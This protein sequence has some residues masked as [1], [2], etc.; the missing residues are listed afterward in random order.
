MIDLDDMAGDETI[1]HL[2]IRNH[3]LIAAQHARLDFGGHINYTFAM[4]AHVSL[5]VTQTSLVITNTDPTDIEP[6]SVC[7]LGD[8]PPDGGELTVPVRIHHTGNAPGGSCNIQAGLVWE[9]ECGGRQN[10]YDVPI[11]IINADRVCSEA[12][13]AFPPVV[14]LGDGPGWVCLWDCRCSPGPPS[15]RSQTFAIPRTL[16]L[17]L[18]LTRVRGQAPQ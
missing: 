16:A 18:Q 17:L 13:S 2:R 5:V 7:D 12:A 14:G 15:A 3:G 6:T 4:A 1:V 9:L 11:A 10:S 8:L